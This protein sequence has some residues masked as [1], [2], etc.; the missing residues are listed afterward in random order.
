[1]L[2]RLL[3][4]GGVI[5]AVCAPVP[6]AAGAAG[7]SAYQRVLGVYESQGTVPACRFSGVE[8]S[9]ALNGVDTYGAQYFADFTQAAQAALNARAAGACPGSAAVVPVR[10]PAGVAEPPAH[11]GS[12]TAATSAGIPAPLA[13]MAVLA[14]VAA[15]FGAGAMVVRSR[16]RPG[17]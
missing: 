16:A 7:Q 15:L 14:L 6:A 5:A 1:M 11:F 13:V 2:R 3:A 17:R 4:I 8:L 12:V 10:A 9:A